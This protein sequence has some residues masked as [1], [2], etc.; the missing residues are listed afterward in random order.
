MKFTRI[1]TLIT[2]LFVTTINMFSQDEEIDDLTF[3]VTPL[4]E[5]KP[6]YFSV[7]GGYMG[8]IVF[9]NFD[10]LNKTAKGLALEE[11]SSPIYM[12]GV[13]G[14]SAIGIIPNLR[15]GFQGMG[16]WRLVESDV[17]IPKNPIAVPPLNDSITVKRSFE[18][19]VSYNGI[20]I[21]YGIILFKSLAIV[22]GITVGWGDVTLES[23]QTKNDIDWNNYGN[24]NNFETDYFKRAKAVF[25]YVQPNLNIEYALTPFFMFRFNAGYFY[26]FALTGDWDWKYNRSASMKNT[27]SDINAS[28]LS[29]QFGLFLGLFNY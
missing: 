28:G 18:Y 19:A 5:E 27:P 25:S 17:K 14:F 13:Q 10:E 1:L 12:S 21:D 4:Q 7:A 11:L 24:E 15:L 29:V 6:P 22:P 16:G 3:E 8:T 20:S 26:S 9:L 2:L 23:F